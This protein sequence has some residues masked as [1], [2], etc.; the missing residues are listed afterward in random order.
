MF[1]GTVPSTHHATDVTWSKW[2]AL[3]TQQARIGNPNHPGILKVTTDW[4]E[5]K[6]FGISLNE[7]EVTC[8]EEAPPYNTLSETD[9]QY[10][11]FTDGSCCLVGNTEGGKLLCEVPHDKLQKPLKDKV[12]LVNLQK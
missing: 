7:E 12:N 11:L 9:K 6:D 10:A 3:I 5:S 1:K 2:T 8:A 4:P